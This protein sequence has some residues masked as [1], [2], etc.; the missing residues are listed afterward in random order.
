MNDVGSL[1]HPNGSKSGSSKSPFAV[2]SNMDDHVFEEI[3]KERQVEVFNTLDDVEPF[4][5]EYE[6][7]S[8]NRLSVLRS[9]RNVYRHYVC[10]EH[11][12]CTFQILIGKRRGDGLYTV[13]RIQNSH[14]G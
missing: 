3:L 10:K 9:L 12:N 1:S 4:I 7:I 2:S 6:N 5:E 14:S 13:K 11:L 8:G